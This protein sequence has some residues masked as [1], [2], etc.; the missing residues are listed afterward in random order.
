MLQALFVFSFG[1]P[2]DQEPDRLVE[3]EAL[4][5]RYE[6]EPNVDTL[7]DANKKAALVRSCPEPLETHLQMNLQ[8]YASYGSIRNAVQS[9]TE[10]KRTWRS[11][12]AQASASTDM[13]VDAV[14][15]DG[16]KGKSKGGKVKSK[17]PKGDECYICGKRGHV[18]K[19]RWN[20]DTRGEKGKGK[21]KG[22]GKQKSKSKDKDKTVTE[23]SQEDSQ[24]SNNSQIVASFTSD[25]IFA[26]TWAASLEEIYESEVEI[27]LDSGAYDHVCS[28]HSP[29]LP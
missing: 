26:V 6:A 12:A 18:Q 13:E 9:Y 24:S 1:S 8:A 17:N 29:L 14:C 28:N 11:E 5:L 4:I 20:K 16:H 3:F 22:K 25:W 15:K 10:G 27:L 7:S 21:V 19:D 2:V 23:V